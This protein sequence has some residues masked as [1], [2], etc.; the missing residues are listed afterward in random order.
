MDE[1]GGLLQNAAA[2]EVRG[3]EALD[4]REWAEAI[5]NLRLG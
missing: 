3:S 2:Y 1:V 4:K 5:A